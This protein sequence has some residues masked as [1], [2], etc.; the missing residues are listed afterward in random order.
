MRPLKVSSLDE[1]N[2]LLDQGFRV[3]DMPDNLY[4]SR[5]CRG[6][7]RSQLNKFAKSPQKLIAS[8]KSEDS[9]DSEAMRFGRIFHEAVLHP[10]NYAQNLITLP[11]FKGIKGNTKQQQFDSFQ[12]LHPDK[13]LATEEEQKLIEAMRKKLMRNETFVRV[14]SNPNCYREIAFFHKF[15]NSWVRCKCDLIVYEHN[16][17][18]I[19]DLKT[20]K[21]NGASEHE[22]LKAIYNEDARLY[23]QDALYSFVVASALGID[24]KPTFSFIA[25]EKVEPFETATFYLD[26]ESRNLSTDKVMHELD[27]YDACKKLDR[28]PS[29]PTQP[30]KLS[31]PNFI[32]ERLKV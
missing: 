18:S 8:Q 28:W 15:E 12:A 27:L 6:I 11:E 29:Y 3:F 25:I 22:F 26:E 14:T 24:I 16:I 9:E 19:Y 10:L 32:K 21:E 23:A 17:A 7:S 2:S 13:I 4:H 20:C 30:Q 5:E 31:L 1:L